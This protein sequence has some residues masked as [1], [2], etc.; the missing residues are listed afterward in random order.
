MFNFWG[1]PNLPSGR[2]I[3]SNPAGERHPV[4]AGLVALALVASVIGIGLTL[5]TLAGLRLTGLTGG[6]G[7]SAP[8]PGSGPTLYVPDPE[9]TSDGSPPED[10]SSGS[11]PATPGSSTSP[12][13]TQRP[14]TLVARPDRV[15]SFERI[16]LSGEYPSGNGAILQVQRRENG[17]WVNFAVTASV[18]G[19]SFETYVQTSRSGPN[20]WRMKDTDTGRLSNVVTVTVG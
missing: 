11:D 13:S 18:E 19:G 7:D 5:A 4:V 2:E 16:Y 8:Q 17:Q 12:D 6:G 20:P 15:G 14:I 3:L 1:R 10:E 9:D